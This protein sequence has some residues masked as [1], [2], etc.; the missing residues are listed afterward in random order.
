MPRNFAIS[1]FF[2]PTGIKPRGIFFVNVISCEV[3]AIAFIAL[4]KI[5]LFPTT[6]MVFAPFFI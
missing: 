4:L 5:S 1:L 3:F 6:T 2:F